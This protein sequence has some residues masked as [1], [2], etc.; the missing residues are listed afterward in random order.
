MLIVSNYHY[1][2][3]DFTTKH[4]SIF[5]LTPNQFKRQLEKLSKAGCFISQNELLNFRDKEFDKNYILITFD[6]G[7]KEQY[8]LAKPI[9]DAMGIPFIFFI[10][11]ANFDE[12]KVSLVHK[13]HLLRSRLSSAEILK[14]LSKNSPFKLT[15]REKAL[16]VFHYNYDEAQTAL[17]KYFLN[18]KMSLLQQQEFI[19]PLFKKL[20]EEKNLASDL[21][22]EEEML[23]VLNKQDALGSHSHRHLPLGK[24]S[25]EE[26]HKELSNTQQFFQEKFGKPAISISYPYGSLEA[27]TEISEQVNIHG[28]KL[29]F[30]MERAYNKTLEH[31]SLM[32]SRFDCND[33]PLGKNE[34]FKAQK[35][36]ENPFV[37]TWYKN[38][39]SFTHKL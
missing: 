30:T 21:Y 4:P 33:M 25:S 34:L 3:E 15:P 39:K 26:L 5:G 10:N 13:I 2:R 37:R 24:L 6:D 17:L 27:S 38:E 23:Q 32:L 35:L 22:F 14:E 19:N 20:Y 36:F 12:K 18:F 8:E 28:F 7:L 9:L 1:I 16:A 29:G 11:T 31:D